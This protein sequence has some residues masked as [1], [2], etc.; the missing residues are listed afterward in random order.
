MAWRAL[1]FAILVFPAT[2]FL[3]A[4]DD[5]EPIEIQRQL[6]GLQLGDDLD[7]VRHVYPPVKD[8]PSKQERNGV[9][10]YH[11]E[12][13]MTKFYPPRVETLYLGF[14]RGR[15]VEIQ[16]VYNEKKS[17]EKPVEKLAG[18]F[19][20]LYGEPKRSGERFWWM[21][22]ETVLRVFPAEISSGHETARAVA[23]R[24]AIQVFQQ[25]LFDR[26]E[27]L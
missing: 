22:G 3:F 23:W 25:G 5:E 24:S 1:L 13:S 8:W 20:L 10:R 11:I 16:L 2:T 26:G 18:D 17:R 9:I 15:L 6:V 21:D 27:S 12:R 19:A 4:Q 14:R 7:R